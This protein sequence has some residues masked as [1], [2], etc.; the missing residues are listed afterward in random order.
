MTFPCQLIFVEDPGAANFVL[1]LSA[2]LSDRGVKCRLFA[3]ETAVNFLRQRGE[4]VEL[5]ANDMT[6]EALMDK[7]FYSAVVVGTSVN[8]KSLSFDLIAAAK[9]RGIPSIGIVDAIVGPHFRFMGMSDDPLKHAPD[10]LL[11]PNDPTRITFENL[12]MPSDRL[13]VV[14][15]PV[16]DA[17]AQAA[18]LL[19]GNSF[20]EKR[21]AIFGEG[22]SDRQI[23]VFISER[24]DGPDSTEYM[25]S[26]EYVLEGWGY[27]KERTKIVLEE[28]LYALSSLS[29][30]PALMVRLH[31][32]EDAADYAN[33]I[34]MIDGFTQGN[35]PYE[36]IYFSDGIV[37][38]SSTLLVEAAAMG[39]PVLS[40][41]PRE[42]ECD[43]VPQMDG[44][45]ITTVTKHSEIPIAL[46]SML[47]EERQPPFN[48]QKSKSID[49]IADRLARI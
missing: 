2:A 6:A 10:T 36:E 7:D 15:S 43:W 23:L 29:P 41:L 21:A 8:P 18:E 16:V 27:T 22:C 14:G 3:R 1:G 9:R 25:K 5:I 32:R 46:T 28:V 39:V 26:A 49:V 30:R 33:Y 31:P 45:E 4:H 24:S 13:M 48:Q 17:A 40:I 35:D 11:V 44:I 20:D 47:K 34:E 42:K 19:A 12:G 38:L 37:G